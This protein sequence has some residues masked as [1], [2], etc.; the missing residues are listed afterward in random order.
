[1]KNRDNLAAYIFYGIIFFGLIL[2]SL[3]IKIEN[4]RY[5]DFISSE[6]ANSLQLID[7]SLLSNEKLLDEI[8]KSE[9]ITS[10]ELIA[11][12]EN[13]NAISENYKN[14]ELVA[15]YLNK[16]DENIINNTNINNI[17][18]S[19]NDYL[20]IT[21]STTSSCDNKNLSQ[22]DIQNFIILKNANDKWQKILL[23]NGVKRNYFI[24]S[25]NFIYSFEVLYPLDYDNWIN[26][27]Y[28]F[29]SESD[30][31]QTINQN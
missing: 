1:M 24:G 2:Y 23:H 17:L 18:D 10:D 21:L 8:I 4:N 5:E 25:E 19:Y 20:S 30:E 13:F 15:S 28:Q 27:I 11:L 31:M 26:I 6:I 29:A 3:S 14:L 9:V 7:S 16:I 12:S 22:E